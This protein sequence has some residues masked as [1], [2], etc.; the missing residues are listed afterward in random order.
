MNLS[1]EKA[2]ELTLDWNKVDLAEHEVLKDV[3]I[4]FKNQDLENIMIKAIKIDNVN[5]VQ[6]L[7]KKGF[8]TDV[9]FQNDL[10]FREQDGFYSDYE[11]Q[12]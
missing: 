6:L 2:L 8:Q 5:F 1:L 3:S 9:I 11:Y 10:L 7:I 12:V 4:L